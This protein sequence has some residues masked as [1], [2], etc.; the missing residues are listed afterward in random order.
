MRLPTKNF[1][2]VYFNGLA[3]TFSVFQGFYSSLVIAYFVFLLFIHLTTACQAIAHII[4]LSCFVVACFFNLHP[5]SAACLFVC[6]YRY[7]CYICTMHNVKNNSF[8]FKLLNNGFIKKK[9]KQLT[10]T[11][12]QMRTCPIF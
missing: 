3:F 7:C 9:I 4:F 2:R 8:S 10:M 1:T 11:N 5:P 6:P 12:M